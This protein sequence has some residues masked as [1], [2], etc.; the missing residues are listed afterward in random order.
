[1][2]LPVCG[3]VFFHLSIDGKVLSRKYT[4]VSKVNERG[5]IEFVIKIYRKTPEFPS[6]GLFTLKLSEL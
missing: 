3:H 4:P 2:G 5:L 6:G 1:M